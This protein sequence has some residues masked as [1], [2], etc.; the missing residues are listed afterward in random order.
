MAKTVVIQNVTIKVKHII[1]CE[2]TFDSEF[3]D[4]ELIIHTTKKGKIDVCFGAD[5]S[6]RN[7]CYVKLVKLMET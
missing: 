1:G 4:Y 6:A 2:A 5:E 7:A 3:D